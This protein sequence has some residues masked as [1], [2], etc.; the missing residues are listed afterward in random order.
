MARLRAEGLQ[1]HMEIFERS[2]GAGWGVR[3]VDEPI[4]AGAYIMEYVGEYLSLEEIQVT[5]PQA[6][7]I[8]NAYTCKVLLKNA[9]DRAKC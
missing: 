5:G 9:C 8:L 1:H 4:P 7:C 6:Y 3:V 2:C